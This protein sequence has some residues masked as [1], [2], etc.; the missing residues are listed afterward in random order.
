MI[1]NNIESKLRTFIQRKDKLTY[2]VKNTCFGKKLLLLHYCKETYFQIKKTASK[3]DHPFD[4]CDARDRQAHTR[5]THTHRERERD[6]NWRQIYYIF[7]RRGW[8]IGYKWANM[9]QLPISSKTKVPN[10]SLESKQ[11]IKKAHR[12]LACKCRNPRKIPSQYSSR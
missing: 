5:H 3:S 2:Y 11:L 10:S 4:S 9:S 6:R 1:C 7:L 8:K 12:W